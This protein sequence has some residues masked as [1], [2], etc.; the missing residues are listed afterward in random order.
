MSGK[1]IIQIPCFNEEGTLPATLRDLPRTVD[2][3]DRVEW[4]VIDDGSSDQTLK[5]AREM[6]VDHIVHHNKN[7][8]LAQAFVTGLEASLRLG[9]DVIVNTDGDNQ[10]NGGDIS[11][12]VAPLRNGD[13]DIVIGSRPVEELRNYGP[14][15]RALHWLGRGLLRWLTGVDVP[16][17]PSGFRAFSREAAER[18][19][20]FSGTTYT[21]ETILQAG[22]SGLAIRSVPIRVNAE[23]RPSRL[24]RNLPGYV[25]NSAVTALRTALIYRPASVFL[26]LATASTAAGLAL[27][28]RFLVFFFS[29]FGKGHIQSVILCALLILLGMLFFCIGVLADLLAVNRKLLEKIEQDV[30]SHS[31]AR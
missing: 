9:A 12:L 19:N 23:F 4:L 1:L 22:A 20:V 26:G 16:D 13:A 2:G 29:G 6:G 30:R 5:I 14:V 10:Y 11:K 15:K 28:I 27:G 31:V 17:P 25:V 8:G 18:V 21:L 24:I 7:R 3:F